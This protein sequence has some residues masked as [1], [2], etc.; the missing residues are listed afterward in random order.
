MR[1]RR[2][3]RRSTGPRVRRSIRWRPF[4][5]LLLIVNLGTAAA[6]SL[7]T[8]VTKVRV[9][10][11]V[12]H[13]QERLARILAQM[14]D[15]PVLRQDFRILEWQ[16]LQAPEVKSASLSVNPFGFASLRVRYRTPI[17]RMEERPD[18]VS[19]SDGVLFALPTQAIPEG[20]PTLKLDRRLPPTLLTVAGDWPVARIAKLASEVRE[21]SGE[22][23]VRI[24]VDDRGALCLNMG[25]GRVVLGSAD[26]LERKLSVLR[27]RMAQ[28][29]EE[30]ARVKELNLTQPDRPSVVP[31][32]EVNSP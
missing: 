8:R 26:D 5:W 10:G 7:A 13:D 15:K 24:E 16:A 32:S 3:R 22:K 19:D 9:E 28:D 1:R 23:G 14:Q 2:S 25:A 29:P 17:L 11:A 21:L 20:L 12:P 30:L 31:K 4:L 18:V 27:Q 6:S